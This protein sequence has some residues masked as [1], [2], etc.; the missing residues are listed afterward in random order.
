MSNDSE[1]KPEFEN[2]SDDFEQGKLIIV[3]GPSGAGKS[4]LVHTVMGRIPRLR[5]SISHTTR[6][7]RLGEQPGVDYYFVSEAEFIAL[8]ER[9]EFLEC[10]NVHQHLYGTSLGEIE[11][12]RAAGVDM[13]LDIDVQGAEQVRRKVA[14]AV[15]I[16]VLPPS[17]AVLEERLRLRNLNRPD[18]LSRRLQDAVLEVRRTKDFEYVILNEDLE[19]AAD[20]LEAIILAQRHRVERRGKLL[21]KI[22][23]TFGGE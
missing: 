10:A 13:L 19:R 23:D 20:A 3:C 5:F 14:D 4:T 21:K 12:G 2:A 9:G 8:R 17:R 11:R 6:A 7:A 22:I 15:T 18:D 16:M 1:T